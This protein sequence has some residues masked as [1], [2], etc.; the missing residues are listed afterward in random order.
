MY[1][2][3]IMWIGYNVSKIVNNTRNEEKIHKISK[4][5]KSK[6]QQTNI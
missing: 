6:L 3:H 2:I 5:L 4:T 1:P